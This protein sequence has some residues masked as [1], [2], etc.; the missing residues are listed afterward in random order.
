VKKSRDTLHPA[1]VK[2][3]AGRSKIAAQALLGVVCY[4]EAVR[5]ELQRH[6]AGLGVELDIRCIPGWYF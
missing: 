5:G 1:Q 2:G 3:Q 4:T 6:T